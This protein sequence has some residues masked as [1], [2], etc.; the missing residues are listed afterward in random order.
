MNPSE[1][2][3]DTHLPRGYV[4]GG[5]RIEKEI[6]RG[7]MGCVYL[8]EHL[9]LKKPVAIK[10]ILPFQDDDRARRLFYREAQLCAQIDHPNVVVIH[11]MNEERGTPYIVMQYVEGKNLSEY[12]ADQ[13]G[14]I[15]WP[16]VLK[17]MRLVLRGLMA[18]HRK[19]LLHRDIKPSNIMVSYEGRVLLMDFGLVRDLATTSLS[20]DNLIVGTPHF[21]SPEQCRGANLDARSDVFSVGA[22]LYNLLTAVLPFGKG[23]VR[24]ILNRITNGEAPPPV[25]LVNPAVPRAVSDLVARAMDFDPRRRYQSAEEL[26]RAIREVLARVPRPAGPA[27]GAGGSP[28]ASAVP[29]PDGTISIGGLAPALAPLEL[30]SKDLG[31]TRAWWRRRGWAAVGLVAAAALIGLVVMALLGDPSVGAPGPRRG[32]PAFDPA[33]VAKVPA[34]MAQLGASAEK[35]REFYAQHGFE[36]NVNGLD[37]ERLVYVPEFLIDKYEVTNADYLKFVQARGY[38][39]LPESWE[40]GRPTEAMMPLPV[41]GITAR[42]AAEYA[43]WAGGELPTAAQWMRAFH[44]ESS[45]LF[46]WGDDWDATRAN[47]FEN[48]GFSEILVPVTETPRDVGAFGVYNLVGNAAEY[49]RPEQN[50][51]TTI[52]KGAHGKASGR[53]YGIGAINYEAALDSAVPF[54]GFRCVYPAQP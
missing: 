3:A 34:G 36:L 37:R 19:G 50:A 5:C 14:P 41:V 47:V 35:V 8:A 48:A 12:L 27:G 33:R 21:M 9:R 7:G 22:T 46:P 25:H 40:G 26:Y 42:D 10:T 16:T 1:Q 38:T 15:P 32:G 20:G 11:D 54:T 24:A 2:G 53:M 44:G 18:V 30:I 13:Q 28:G 17:V 39:R 4:I 29:E 43:R 49:L 6:K 51:T 45:T 23:S 31:D 52:S